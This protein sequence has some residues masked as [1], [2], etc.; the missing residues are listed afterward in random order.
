MATQYAMDY[1]D[2]FNK[3]QKILL[4][5][6][7][8]NLIRKYLGIA[9]EVSKDKKIVLI[10]PN[11]YAYENKDLIYHRFRTYPLFGK[12]LAKFFN[13]LTL[14]SLSLLSP[15]LAFALT[16]DQFFSGAGD[17]FVNKTGQANWAAARDAADG[18]NADATSTTAGVLCQP[19]ADGGWRIDRIFLPFDTAAIPDGVT[20]TSANLNIMLSSKTDNVSGVTIDLVTTSQADTATLATADFDQVGTT[21]QAAALT[22]ASMTTDVYSTYTLNA[23]G[24]SNIS[25]TGFTKFGLRTSHDTDNTACTDAGTNTSSASFY[26]SEET[27]T[28]KDPYLLVSYAGVVGYRSLLGVGQG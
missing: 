10:S 16:T 15:Q 8:I 18:T 3:Y 26:M 20:I 17:G 22:I 14:F 9:Y 24:I 4:F 2:L 23:T 1:K 7:N 6:V 21:E 12:K 5:L 11:S 19:S 25:K 13:L 28:S 27:G